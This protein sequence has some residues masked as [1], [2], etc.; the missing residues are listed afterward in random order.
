MRRDASRCP[1]LAARLRHSPNSVGT[2]VVAAAIA[3]AKRIATTLVELRRCTVTPVKAP[4]ASRVP[5]AGDHG[6]RPCASASPGR[7]STGR[8]GRSGRRRDARSP[9]RRDDERR[10]VQA[11]QQE[12]SHCRHQLNA[13][14]C[15]RSCALRNQRADICH[16]PTSRTVTDQTRDEWTTPSTSAGP[17]AEV[18]SADCASRADQPPG[19]RS[20]RAQEGRQRGKD[21]LTISLL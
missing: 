13:A 10:P 2:V 20:D 5:A 19:K 12:G 18:R 4:S 16:P 11:A 14:D 15:P 6:R 8:S 1:S 3:Q 7:R 9:Q 17:C 21:T